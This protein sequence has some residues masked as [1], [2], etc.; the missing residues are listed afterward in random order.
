[1]VEQNPVAVWVIEDNRPL[2]ETLADVV[3]EHPAMRCALA[4]EGYEDALAALERG[5]V[6]HVV[7]SDLELPGID[8]I[9]GIRR[10]KAQS[11]ATHVV[12]LTIHEDDDR[13]FNALCA[14]A[15]GYLLKPAS[16]ERIVEAIQTAVSGGAPMNAYIASKVL[17]MFTRYTR[18]AADYGLTDREREILHLL[19]EEH[20]QREVAEALF[21]SPHTV[22]TH[23]RNIYAK[24]QVHSRTGAVA[25]ALRERLL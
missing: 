11:P 16:G 8:G 3:N 2:R 23:L 21:L 7:L 24:L 13:V 6:P 19:V 18:P 4:T 20:T 12:V 25:K 17:R 9:E 15:T 22:D 14:G 1:M 5:E 10:L